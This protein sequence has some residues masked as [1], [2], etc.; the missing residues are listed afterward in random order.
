MAF[1]FFCFFCFKEIRMMSNRS[2]PAL[3]FSLVLLFSFLVGPPLGVAQGK[4]PPT[5]EEAKRSKAL[6]EEKTIRDAEQNLQGSK[7]Q[8][9]RL[10]G[11]NKPGDYPALDE[12]GPQEGGKKLNPS[13]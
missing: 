13:D 8:E 7:R 10:R 4:T 6:M 11:R 5:E 3:V 1:C 9:M 12:K 2:F